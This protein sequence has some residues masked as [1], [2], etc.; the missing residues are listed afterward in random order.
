VVG[1]VGLCR[2]NH[3]SP[4]ARPVRRS[5]RKE[6]KIMMEF[7]G[8]PTPDLDALAAEFE[9]ALSCFRLLRV[10]LSR[11]PSARAGG[12]VAVTSRPGGHES[13][14]WPPDTAS[15]GNFMQVCGF[16]MRFRVAE[17]ALR[18]AI[19]RLEMVHSSPP[20]MRPAWLQVR[21]CRK[22]FNGTLRISPMKSNMNAMC[23]VKSDGIHSGQVL[24][25]AR[26][27]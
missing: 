1:T 2:G 4:L 19:A 27:G 16:A 13:G 22:C 17:R 14:P 24:M 25:P 18:S 20:I 6:I 7:R 3:P 23:A 15:H 5:E 8:N 11:P 21:K 10:R 12:T 26:L 9:L